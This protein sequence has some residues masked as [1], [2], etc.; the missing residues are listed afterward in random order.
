MG[1]S[2]IPQLQRSSSG[3][4]NT[5]VHLI[6][7]KYIVISKCASSSVVQKSRALDSKLRFTSVKLKN[8]LCSFIID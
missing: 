5:H 8:V 2:L 1:R 6:M 3:S 4:Q 7:Q